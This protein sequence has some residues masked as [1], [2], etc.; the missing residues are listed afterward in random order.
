MIK[1]GILTFHRSLNYGAF[2]QCYAL[3]KSI[4]ELFPEVTVEVFDY[5]TKISMKQYFIVD[6]KRIIK[7]PYLI[8]SILYKRRIFNKAVKNLNISECKLITDDYQKVLNKLKNRYDF[9]IVGSDVVWNMTRKGF[10]NVYWLNHE[11]FCKKLGYGISSHGTNYKLISQEKLSYCVEAIAQFDYVG[12]R[13]ESTMSFVKSL[14]YKNPYH[15]CDPT[16]LLDLNKVGVNIEQLQKK[17]FK[18]FNLDSNKKVIAVMTSNIILGKYFIKNYG[19]EYNVISLYTYNPAIK[20]FIYNLDPFQWAR[21]FSCCA[22]T[23]TTFFHGSIF[24]FMNLTPVIAINDKKLDETYKGKIED[25]MD[26]FDMKEYFFHLSEINNNPDF[27]KRQVEQLLNKPPIDK[28]VTSLETERKYFDSF[29][30]KM[31]ELINHI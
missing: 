29:R 5:T 8:K 27:I 24:S 16:L 2:L 4:S 21:F 11:M 9:L 19:R 25:L 17:I 3:Q 30:S 15:N 14:G 31:T 22:L 7:R 28:I 6:I 10:P 20:K 26:R 13:D 12:V 23:V 18:K 1:I